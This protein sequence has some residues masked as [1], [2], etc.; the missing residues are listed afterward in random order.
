[1]LLTKAVCR[2]CREPVM[3][4]FTRYQCGTAH[5]N[6]NFTAYRLRNYH[7]NENVIVIMALPDDTVKHTAIGNLTLP[8]NQRHCPPGDPQ[9]GGVPP[10]L[11]RPS[12]GRSPGSVPGVP[13][14]VSGGCGC[15]SAN[16]WFLRG[17][18]PAVQSGGAGRG[19]PGQ[20]WPCRVGAGLNGN[21][22]ALVALPVPWARRRLP[23]PPSRSANLLC[24]P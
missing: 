8:L 4:P 19:R 2:R 22:K 10:P 20:S 14:Y 16:P 15:W 18:E 5:D 9:H 1:M 23:G 6:G 7:D 11:A 13:G 17:R 24:L 12:P 21:G 3:H